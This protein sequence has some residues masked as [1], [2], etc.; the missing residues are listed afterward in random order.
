[1][2]LAD[3]RDMSLSHA[4]YDAPVDPLMSFRDTSAFNSI[5]L[6]TTLVWPDIAATISGV[7][8]N[9]PYICKCIYQICHYIYVHTILSV[10]KWYH[11]THA[12]IIWFTCILL[13]THQA[14]HS[15]HHP[16]CSL[17]YTLHSQMHVSN[18]SL[19]ICS[20]YVV[21]I[22]RNISWY[23]YMGWLRSVGSIKL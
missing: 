8:W 17:K 6:S 22:I 4:L 15:W 19:Y 10:C 9:T 13:R 1:M 18:L 5:S 16:W 21:Q 12:S 20:Y 23:T 14:R 7:R 3:K 11:Y 2:W